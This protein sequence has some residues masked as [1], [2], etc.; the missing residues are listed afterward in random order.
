MPTPS[1][2]RT[3]P[4][5]LPERLL[6]GMTLA[7]TVGQLLIIG[8]DGPALSPELRAVIEQCYIGGV[9]LSG[10]NGNIEG[11]QQVAQLSVD[12]QQAAAATGQPGLF[13]SIDQEGGRVA[14]LKEA[15]G[16]TELPSAMALAATGHVNNVRR[17]AQVFAREMKAV[18]LN[19]NFAPVLDVNVN[20]ANPVIGTRAYGSDPQRVAQ[21]GVAFLK[22][23]QDEGV[24]AIGKH[25]P[26]H[27]DTDIDS[28]VA[29]PSV[30]HGRARLEAVEF[31]PFRAA[32]AAGVAGIMS[33]HVTFPAFDGGG[34][35]ATLS[36]TVLTG[37][38]RDEWGYGGLLVTDSLEMG[39][40]SKSLGL[41][42]AQAAAA[43]LAAGAD[44]LLFNHDHDQ[45]RQAHAL[46]VQKVQ[47]GEI[48]LARL[49]QAVLRALRA[50]ERFNLLSPGLSDA[51]LAA[52][53]VFR[54]EDRALADDLAAQSIT[55]LRDDSRLLP[56]AAE[57]H[58]VVLEIPALAGLGQLLGQAAI[59]LN[60][61]PSPAEI[62]EVVSRVGQGQPCIVGVADV[63]RSPGQ[64]E[65]V[66]A[67]LRRGVPVVLVAARD[68][69]DLL[70]FP[71]AP[72]L[73]ATYASPPPS[74][75]ALAAVLTGQA[76]P[77][78]HLPVELP[79]L[80]P[81]GAGLDDFE[82]RN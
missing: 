39:A 53:Q 52:S 66:N 36:Q 82:Q 40:L 22:G 29:L 51:A 17:A 56:L 57:A 31:V 35:P 27:G 25:F 38:L 60:A 13:M 15:Q 81:L 50:K 6:A 3:D 41:S 30:P 72:T 55:L 54:H 20:P 80:F 12:L 68:P 8:F 24:L 62:G 1:P 67:L 18:G 70:A 19:V 59:I 64:I 45:H 7:Q 9:I 47:R 75:R 10:L 2:N 16:F 69:Y 48:P 65:L 71:A 74:L 78:G 14:R 26:G 76:K 33:A 21:Y 61:Q 63:T 34:V 43:A 58:P 37:L 23:L 44:L 79:G 46:I 42:P 4:S 11:P 73:L 32:M 77:G 5:G 28:H 49:D